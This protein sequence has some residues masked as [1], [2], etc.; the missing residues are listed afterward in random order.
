MQI[1]PY[2]GKKQTLTICIQY[3]NDL[4]CIISSSSVY[5][6]Y[7]CQC[8]GY[9]RRNP[10]YILMFRKCLKRCQIVLTSMELLHALLILQP[11]PLLFYPIFFLE[12]IST[13]LSIQVIKQSSRF[14][15]YCHRHPY[16]SLRFISNQFKI[17]IC[18]VPRVILR[19]FTPNS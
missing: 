3:E 4:K 6:E 13:I 8:K 16:C 7:S 1:V 18:I 15:L 17:V 2:K 10:L 9:S 19:H 14:F 5:G 11:L 12:L